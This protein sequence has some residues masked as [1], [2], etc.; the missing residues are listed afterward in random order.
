MKKTMKNGRW[1]LLILLLLQTYS[2]IGYSQGT[3]PFQIANKS[4][5]PDDQVYIG[6]TGRVNDQSVW[7]DCATQTV[8]PIQLSDNTVTAPNGTKYA[9][10]FTKLSNIPNKTL[11]L[12][13]I[14]S[15]R[16]FIAFKNQLYLYFFAD[17]GYSAPDL[18]NPTDPNQGIRYEIIELTYNNIGLW[19]NTTRVDNYQYPMGLEVW[20]SNIPYQK[21]G[22]II[23]HQQILDL[24]KARVP[25]SFQ[26]CYDA[27]LGIIHAPSKTAPFKEGGS[28]YNYFDSYVNAVWA[29]YRNEDLTMSIGDAGVWRGRV[30]GDVFTFTRSTDGAVGV[31]EAKPNTQEILEGKGV[32]AHDVPSTPT[33]NDLDVQKHFCAGFNRGAINPN[34][35]SGVTQSWGNEA[36]YFINNT[37]NEYVK[38]WHSRDIS[39]DGWT[40]AFCY[41]DVFEKS[42]TIMATNPTKAIITIGGFA[43]SPSQVLT[44]IV[45]SPA[46]A[47][48]QQNANQ[49][50]TATCYDQNGATMSITPT[51]ST[52]GGTIST[53]GLFTG[54]SAGTFTVRATSGSV[55]GTA[56]VT[57]NP[58]TSTTNLAL[59]KPVTTS[60]TENAGTTGNYAVDGN[61]GTRW[62]SAASDPQWIQIDLQGTFTINKVVLNWETAAGKSFQI[63]TSADGTNWTNIYSTTTSTGGLQ[64]LNVSGSGRYI[65]MYGT[66]RTTGYGY[67]LWEFEVYGSVGTNVPVTGV[68]VS[69]TTASVA[70]GATTQLAA[71]VAPSN[72]TNKNVSW[73]SSNTSVATVNATG[74]VTGVAAGSAVITVTTQDGNKTATS[75]ITVTTTNIPVTGVTVNQTSASLTTGATLQLTATVAPSNA[76][77]K[78]VTWTSS[79]TAVATVNATGLVTAVASGNANITVTTQDGAKTAIC[80]VAVA[81]PYTTN[82]AL[83]KPITASSVEG[84]NVATNANDGSTGTRW[85]SLFADPQWIRIDLQATYTINKVVLNWEAAAGKSFQIQVSSDATNWT[86]IYTTTTGAG[87]I[88]TLTV[89]G[90]G[91]YIRMYGTVRTSGWGYSLWEFEVYGTQGTNVPV[92]GVTVAPTTVSLVL[93][94][95]TQLTATVAPSNAT[96]KNVTW[97]SSNTAVA[98]VNAS[99]LVTAVASGMA[100]ITVTTQD[101]AKTAICATTVTAPVATNVAIGKP[102]TASS[103]EG[104][105]VATNA[106]D[107]NA[108]TRWG[109]L[110]ADPQWIQIDLQAS[111]SISRVVLNWEAAAGKSFQI[112]VSND[113]VNWTNIYTTTTGVGGIQTLTVSGTGRY[114]RMY[115]TVR[116]TGWGY[117]LWEFEVY[118]VTA[119]SGLSETTTNY[120]NMNEVDMYPN[121][122]IDQLNLKLPSADSYNELSIYDFS[123]KMILRQKIAAKEVRVNLNG[124]KSGLYMLMLNGSQQNKTLK[125]VKK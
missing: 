100:N 117:S 6:L 36:E 87:G 1:I 83:G 123:G 32:L 43:N 14:A 8:K 18:N 104:A 94:A 52:T 37:Y 80:A 119:K 11:N 33:A 50:F 84:A 16:I 65:R 42:S 61:A 30:N 53:S 59:N 58:I 118:G 85:G 82:I 71:T 54:S 56:T 90:T 111:Y 57:V 3:L 67:S 19:A 115:G 114:I 41:D 113:G 48:I 89:S 72:A 93:G 122:V 27:N 17:G 74:L 24:W 70:T 51:W 44:S 31:I 107:G 91:R 49:Q 64:T 40:Y 55:S 68:S 34:A 46:T 35:P 9:N 12:P 97:T 7:F 120:N 79:N 5:F 110:F 77:N 121:P 39:Y 92:T 66:V 22:E 26:G 76:T 21:V 101:G 116:T 38:F 99:G 60:S 47:S 73:T 103:V 25:A 78:N 75:S 10:C 62:S 81:A 15:V 4:E 29:R 13:Q 88:Q 23:T 2:F 63:Q 98:T 95:T 124:L 28:M 106:N 45:V 96:N 112:Q 20:G 109:S 69:P 86:N 108:G 105:N 102:I 125:I